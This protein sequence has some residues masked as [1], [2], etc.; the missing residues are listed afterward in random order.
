MGSMASSRPR[1]SQSRQVAQ[2]GRR[3]FLRK[4]TA[5]DRDEY[6]R[7]RRRS[8]A[9]LKSWEP[10]PP[11]GRT[12]ARQF[13]DWL[14][15]SR[16][17]RHEKLLICRL[18]DGALL[19]AIN[20]NE[21]VPGPSQSGFLGYWIGAP[22]ARQ[23]YMTEALQLALRQA[24]RV[25]GL[26]RVEANIMPANRASIALVKRAGFR[27]EGYSARYLKIAGRWADHERWALLA[28]DWRPCV[29]P[30]LGCASHGS[31]SRGLR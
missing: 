14:R 24:F 22:Y 23:G 1:L 11:R 19:G 21:I 28:E 3:V 7:L 20:V 15:T 16:R 12:A 10:A 9:F 26:H 17:G 29:R 25:L 31:R 13:V 5:R 30:G 4:P 8:A 18:H 2:A 6:V 27:R